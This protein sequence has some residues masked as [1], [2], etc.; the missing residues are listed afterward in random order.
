[1]PRGCGETQVNRK[2]TILSG[3]AVLIVA[4]GYGYRDRLEAA[5]TSTG[6]GAAAKPGAVAKAEQPG[7]RPGR[8]RGRRGGG[9]VPV[10]VGKVL[11]QA[12]PRKLRVIGSA[13][14]V[15]TVAVKSR[16]DGQVLE[17]YFKEGQTVAKG[18]LLFRIDPRPFE[19]ALRRAQ[20]NL[21]RD[22]AQAE[23]AKDDLA[24]Y[25]SLVGKGFAS[26]QKYEEARASYNA[27]K[28][29]L[30]ADEAAIQA[31]KLEL[32]YTTIRSPI[33]GTTGA[34][35][36][37]PGNLVKANDTQPLVVVTQMRPIYVAFSVPERY[38][39][40]I[41]RLMAAGPVT[42]EANL[43][44]TTDA[45]VRG[46]LVFVNST[47]DTNTG[48]ILLKAEFDNA[49]GALTPGQFV[50]VALTLEERPEA[51]VVPSRALQQGQHGTFVFV[52]KDDN[53]VEMRNVVADDAVG[54]MTVITKGLSAGESVVLDGQLL[55]RPG[56]K[57]APRAAGVRTARRRAGPAKL[58]E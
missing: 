27:L 2:T 39:A 11:A 22:R 28:G 29:T 54:D 45:P 1:M 36:I 47:V 34:L 44:R 4:V 58:S 49:D 35:L 43:P 9:P 52:M 15:A 18:E 13:Q 41:K 8:R 50:N 21:D 51:L 20:A 3:L 6:A 26:R 30:R 56:S 42:V 33:A 38:L 55:L 40:R 24:R 48:T 17:A 12:T 7:D 32:D 46:R 5:L 57:V 14:A 16:V 23:K 25:S 37:N 31:A 53:T 19:V 10:V